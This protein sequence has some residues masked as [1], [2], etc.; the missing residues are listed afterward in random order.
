MTSVSYRPE[1]IIKVP[2]KEGEI[3]VILAMKSSIMK[4]EF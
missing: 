3:S 1:V 2:T 4:S